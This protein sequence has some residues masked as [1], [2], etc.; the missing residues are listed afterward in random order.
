MGQSQQRGPFKIS[1]VGEVPVDEVLYDA[2]IPRIKTGTA[3]IR[4]PSNKGLG[5]PWRKTVAQPPCM[6]EREILILL[7]VNHQHRTID[8]LCKAHRADLIKAPFPED[9]HP[10]NHHGSEENTKDPIVTSIETQQ[11]F[12]G[13]RIAA[14]KEQ[15]L[16]LPG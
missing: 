10:K 13:S 12:P 11:G 2:R 5:P 1:A 3:V 16:H 9:L 6:M 4:T 7:S 14:F 15:E 8:F